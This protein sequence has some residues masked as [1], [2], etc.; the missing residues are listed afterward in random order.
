ME[1]LPTNKQDKMSNAFVPQNIGK[2][3]AFTLHT[4]EFTGFLAVSPMKVIRLK[5]IKLTK[6]YVTLERVFKDDEDY[7]HPYR[8]KINDFAW[9]TNGEQYVMITKMNLS[10]KKS[11]K[12][13]II[14]H[15]FRE[16]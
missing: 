13:A 12:F 16:V 10:S 2:T 5:I 9:H 6:H 3:L 7:E 1:A 15:S 14:S 4:E 11:I 8:C